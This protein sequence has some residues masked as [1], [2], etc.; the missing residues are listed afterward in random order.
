MNQTP[1]GV[2]RA[3][4]RYTQATQHSLWTHGMPDEADTEPGRENVKHLRE[5][6]QVSGTSVLSNDELL[7]LVL[8]TASSPARIIRQVQT[9]F[10]SM[11]LQELLTID[12]GELSSK[13][14]LGDAKAAQLQAVL[15]L[16][17][18]LT[19]PSLQEERYQILSPADAANLVMAEMSFLDHEEL[20]VICLDTKNRVVANIR[21]YQGTLNSSVLRVAEIFK[22]AIARNC[23][24][25]IICHNHPSGDPKPSPE[26]EH[27]TRQ[28][29]EAAK[30]FDLEIV[31]HI[32]VGSN[33]RFV[34]MKEKMMW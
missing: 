16:A 12:F 7:S 2:P 23:A 17:R 27:V 6:L 13:Y 8:G 26:D 15:E 19:V 11:S 21:R 14:L 22:P 25:I 3:E 4:F 34:S 20:R 5:R 30:L 33:Q 24:G 32:I 29:V 1:G 10:T 18:R 9:L 31:D 28:L